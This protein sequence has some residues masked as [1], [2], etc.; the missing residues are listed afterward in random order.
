METKG[1]VNEGYVADGPGDRRGSYNP[2]AEEA[3]PV[4]LKQVASTPLRTYGPGEGKR[5]YRNLIIICIAF[6]L[7]FT[8]FQSMAALQ[9][10]LN[11]VVSTY[12]HFLLLF[13]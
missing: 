9:N 6:M 11:N 1:E 12:L 4:E 13:N 5:M 7:L 8:A 10:S 2:G 3:G